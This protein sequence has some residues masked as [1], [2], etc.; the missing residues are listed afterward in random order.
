MSEHIVVCPAYPKNTVPEKAL[1]WLQTSRNP[2]LRSVM[3][4]DFWKCLTRAYWV[5]R[6][7]VQLKH[8][9]LSFVR[10]NVLRVAKSFHEACDYMFRVGTDFWVH[11]KKPLAWGR[12]LMSIYT[13]LGQSILLQCICGKATVF[14]NWFGVTF[15]KLVIPT[16]WSLGYLWRTTVF[17]VHLVC[18]LLTVLF[19][20]HYKPIK[21][22]L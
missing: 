17:Q 10:Q 8:M 7:N 3:P 15:G 2:S 16:V 5:I 12:D 21:S 6:Q 14:G 22:C 13:S 19:F 20:S 11:W 4:D 1:W 18:R 9:K